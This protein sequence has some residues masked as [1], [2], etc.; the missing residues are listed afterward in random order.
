M[1]HNG[2]L[3]SIISI[4]IISSSSSDLQGLPVFHLHGLGAGSES[5]PKSAKRTAGAWG[6]NFEANSSWENHGKT[7][8]KPWE[9][10]GFM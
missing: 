5:P 9:N 2:S 10:G 6:H 3:S 8:G 7:M 4:P 1:D